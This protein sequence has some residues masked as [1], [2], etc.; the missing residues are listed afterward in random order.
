VWSVVKGTLIHHYEEEH[1]KHKPPLLPFESLLTTLY[2]LRIYP[3]IRCIA[4]ELDISV[5]C[6]RECLDHTLD[7]LFTTLVPAEFHHS[8]PLPRAYTTG[9]LAGICAVVDSTF[10]VLPHTDKK[11]DGKKNYHYKSGTRQ[12]LKWQLCVSPTGVPWHISDVVNGAMADI[13]L[14][15]KSELMEWTALEALVLGDKGYVGAWHVVTPKKKPRGGELKEDEK[16]ANKEKNSA[17]AIVENSIHQFKRWAILGGEYRGKWREDDHLKR[18]TKIVHV[19][20]AMVK[21]F[22]VAHPLRAESAPEE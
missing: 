18:A 16:E 7:S 2:W 9:T 21:R 15:E 22:I 14:L 17:R 4:A 3:T 13:K 11:E 19:V 5:T 1:T 12:A 8:P 20:G 6:V 10:L